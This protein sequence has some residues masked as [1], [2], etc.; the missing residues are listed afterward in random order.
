M[1]AG[2][3]VDEISKAFGAWLSGA[4]ADAGLSQQALAALIGLRRQQT[5][6]QIEGGTRPA[7][8]SEVYRVLA[9]LGRPLPSLAVTLPD[10]CTSCWGKPPT[11]FTC[12]SCGAR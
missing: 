3:R 2:I 8:V 7:T 5:I 11:G 1:T 9:A 6:A 4:R 10:V 12:N